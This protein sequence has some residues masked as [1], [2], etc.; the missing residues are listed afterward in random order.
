M[1]FTIIK[2]GILDTV[3][4]TGRYGYQDLGINPGGAMARFSAQ[5]ANALL[6]KEMDAPVIEMHF[7]ASSIQF[8]KST[9][10]CIAGADFSPVINKKIV[11]LLQPVAVKKNQVLTFEKVKSGARCYL[12]IFQHL[13]L[14]KW[15][16]SY[17]TNVKATAGGF[18]G[19]SFKTGDVVGFNENEAISTYLD[20]QD[21][22]VLGWKASPPKEI[23]TVTLEVIKGV[24]W[25]WLTAESQQS[26]TAN[27]FAIT[28]VADRMG[29]RLNGTALKMKAQTEIVSSGVAFGTVQLL[30]NG[31]LIV[32][33]ADHQTTGGYPRVAN[34]IS[35]HLPALAQMKP[36][37]QITFKMIEV[38]EAQQKLL[39]QQQYLQLVQHA[40]S[41]KLKTLLHGHLRS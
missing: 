14:N 20:K 10:I 30:P 5:L 21:T 33:M 40:A 38:K 16:G 19:K 9:I 35:A 25:D 28:N 41:F 26:F 22:R 17:S 6:G 29:Y 12:S 13:H 1:S 23:A 39:K 3:Q 4:D 36:N 18:E 34:V 11:A 27:S 31:Q 32:L 2:A 7:N 37:D 24:E 15:L 8:N